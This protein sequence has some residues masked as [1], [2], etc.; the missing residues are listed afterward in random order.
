MAQLLAM[1]TTQGPRR[2]PVR[3]FEQAIALARLNLTK[4]VYA[5]AEEFSE[6]VALPSGIDVWGGL[7]CNRGW[8]YV[9]TLARR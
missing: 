5:C 2:K 7:D 1:I 8:L 9:G 4:R 3:T 6:A